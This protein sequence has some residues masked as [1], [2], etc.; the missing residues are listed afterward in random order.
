MCEEPI[1]RECYEVTFTIW[2]VT[3]YFMDRG[4]KI[5][6]SKLV[7]VW[8]CVIESHFKAMRNTSMVSLFLALRSSIKGIVNN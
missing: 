5:S 3:E 8:T 2:N 7:F 1:S 6:K 4:R